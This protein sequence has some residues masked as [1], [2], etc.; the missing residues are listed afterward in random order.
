MN[1]INLIS[2]KIIKNTEEN[3]I[4]NIP[5]LFRKYLYFNNYLRKFFQKI[6]INS[7]A[8]YN[9]QSLYKDYLKKNIRTYILVFE[10]L[11]QKFIINNTIE[12]NIFKEMKNDILKIKN[13]FDF[14][15]FHNVDVYYENIQV[16]YLFNM[17]KQ[18]MIT[19]Q[20][21]IPLIEYLNL[22][23]KNNIDI[24]YNYNFFSNNYNLKINYLEK[25]DNDLY[26]FKFLKFKNK[27]SSLTETCN[28]YIKKKKKSFKMFKNLIQDII[29]NLCN[30][31]E[32]I[33]KKK[34]KIKIKKKK[35]GPFHNLS[36][37]DNFNFQENDDYLNLNNIIL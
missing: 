18:N 35:I 15:S 33:L 32:Q 4:N 3:Q 36:L 30:F 1:K 19:F 7:L 26:F 21:L 27:K 12:S 10:S 16:S 28:E 23:D 14:L 29:L 11:L 20:N 9:R 37:L 13:L 22:N 31:T 24:N 17:Q 8:F 5:Y 25:N 34:Y 2:K 6:Q